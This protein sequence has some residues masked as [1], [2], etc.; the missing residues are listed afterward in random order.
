MPAAAFAT[1]LIKAYPDAKVI[2]NTRKD[3]DRWYESHLETFSWGPSIWLAS[4]FAAEVYWLS[5]CH[6]IP[7]EAFYWGS[8]RATG[9]WRYREHVAMVKGLMAARP[10]DLLEWTVQDGWAPLCTFL[11]K[12]VPDTEFPSGNAPKEMLER[13]GKILDDMKR[14]ALRGMI[15]TGAV[16]VGGLSAAAWYALR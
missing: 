9:K 7:F 3:M 13:T 4:W 16:L 2:L 14:T 5:K 1:E 6:D 8:F 10:E 11:G 12:P 15:V